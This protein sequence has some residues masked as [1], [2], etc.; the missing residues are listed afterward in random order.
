MR[1]FAPLSLS[2]LRSLLP[3][4][5]WGGFALPS[6]ALPGSCGR[7]GRTLAP[8]AP[9]WAV[10]APPLPFRAPAAFPAASWRLWRLPGPSRP[11]P[12]PF[13]LL[14]PSRPHRGASGAS[15]GRPGPSPALPGSC[16][17][18]AASQ[19]PVPDR[20]CLWLCRCWSPFPHICVLSLFTFPYKL[21][22]NT[23][24]Q[25]LIIIIK[26]NLSSTL[27]IPQSILL[28]SSIYI[29]LQYNNYKNN[30]EYLIYLSSPAIS[31][32]CRTIVPAWLSSLRQP[33]R[34]GCAWSCLSSHP[35][36][37]IRC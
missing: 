22:T 15:L 21:I 4:E 10:Q 29:N 30:Y 32:C 34:P 37:L 16:G 27:T 25:I 17:Q 26:S 7:P 13:G 1:K 18:M 28:N 36:R 31:H 12:C 2:W 8:L 5:V 3:G 6:P 33:S 11:L 9:P 14:R 19:G 35:G 24:P 20:S 23:P